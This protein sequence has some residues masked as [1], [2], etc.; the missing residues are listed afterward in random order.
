MKPST[1]DLKE[2]MMYRRFKLE[3]A[4]ILG[5]FLSIVITLAAYLTSIF[6]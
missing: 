5:I 3:N 4:L 6:L 2:R 1:L